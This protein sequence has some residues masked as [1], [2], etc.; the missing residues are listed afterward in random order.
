MAEPFDVAFRGATVV[1]HDGAG[2]RDIAVRNGRIAAI[3]EVSAKQAAEVVDGRG[4]HI[5]PLSHPGLSAAGATR[6]SRTRVPDERHRG[7]VADAAPRRDPH[8][9]TD[10]LTNLQ[11]KLYAFEPATDGQRAPTPT[12]WALIG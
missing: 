4:L 3:G 11:V 10:L 8:G 9:G 5:L 12:R 2:V 7:V 1:N 6:S